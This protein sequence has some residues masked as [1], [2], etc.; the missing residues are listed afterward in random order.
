MPKSERGRGR[1][2]YHSDEEEG[3][4]DTGRDDDGQRTRSQSRGRRDRS[5]IAR[6]SSVGR[7]AALIKLR[8]KDKAAGLIGL[9]SSAV[10]DCQS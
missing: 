8:K 7:S 3:D 5:P 6:D 1:R 4:M 10:S 2:T 9:S